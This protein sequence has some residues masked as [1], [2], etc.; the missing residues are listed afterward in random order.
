MDYLT[1]IPQHVEQYGFCKTL[2]VRREVIDWKH[3][4][5][6][7][8]VRKTIDY[9][10]IFEKIGRDIGWYMEYMTNQLRNIH[11]IDRAYR[12]DVNEIVKSPDDRF[13]PLLDLYSGLDVI[14]A[15]DFD[16]TVT[17]RRFGPLYDLC[18]DRGVVHIVTAN[19][20]VT[21]E[22][23]ERR[24]KRIPKKIHAC[25]GK[26]SKINQ[27]LYLNQMYDIVLYVDNESEYLDIAWIFN[28]K[29][30]HWTNNKIKYY[31]RKTR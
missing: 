1:D 9:N 19:P 13:F 25:K 18:V 21:N 31:S 14:I 26:V 4:M 17:D 8:F 15:L 5:T 7:L 30:F 10:R 12:H 22:W 11:H 3:R 6:E 24:N 27:L 2:L 29:T 20:T 16:G 28:V 23:F